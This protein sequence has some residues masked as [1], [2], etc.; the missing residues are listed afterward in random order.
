MPK[1]TKKRPVKTASSNKHKS[2]PA[3]SSA[4]SAK[5][6]GKSAGKSASR[7][8]AKPPAKPAKGKASAKPVAKAAAKPLAK[9]A[10][11]AAAKP[12]TKPVAKPATKPPV[13][14]GPKT[15]TKATDKPAAASS[16]SAK[17]A[18]AKPSPAP[19]AGAGAPVP[20]PIASPVPTPSSPT[21]GGTN[22]L[23]SG[24]NR[25]RPGRLSAMGKAKKP[26]AK[27]I[28]VVMPEFTSLIYLRQKGPLID[29]GPKN[30]PVHNFL[31][32]FKDG[33]KIKP[34]FNKRDLDKYRKI[35]LDKRAELAGDVRSLESEALQTSSGGLS[36]TPQHVAEQ[37]SEAFEQDNSLRLAQKDRE[38]IREIDAAIKRVDSGAYGICEM[39]R[40][41]IELERL[42]ELPWTRDSI[43][44]ARGRERQRLI[45]GGSVR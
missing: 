29:S 5:T 4:S 24:E 21:D 42:G 36:H 40:K 37:G 16:A 27:K 31:G 44:G 3:K 8:A 33:E 6:A 34:V 38:L 7:S 19:A 10:V 9:A 11:K 32:P 23:V 18:P 25:P 1:T 20:P 41:P 17:P 43:E 22:V 15:A 14:F 35:L 45:P 2:A 26:K 12:A 13:K 30:Q 39:T 28:E